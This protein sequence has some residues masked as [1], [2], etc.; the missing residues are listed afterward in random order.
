MEAAALRRLNPVIHERARLG[1]MS[2]LA[3]QPVLSFGELKSL[4]DATDGNLSVHLRTLEE[5]GY[6]SVGKAFVDRKPRTTARLT[7]KG[8]IA[9]EHYVEVLGE[10]VRGR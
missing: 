4:L 10:I 6:V 5:A 8:R 9:F 2:L 1:I 7:R 3:A